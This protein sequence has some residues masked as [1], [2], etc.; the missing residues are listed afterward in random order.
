VNLP[1]G[2]AGRPRGQAA[3]ANGAA[4]G[5]ATGAADG[6]AVCEGGVMAQLVS[7]AYA[8]AGDL[9]RMERAL[10]ATYRSS[11]LRV[12]D[13]SWLSREHSHRE[14]SLYIRLWE[15]AEHGDHLA[16]GASG[17]IAW[18]Y[19]RPNGEFNVFAAPGQGTPDLFKELLDTIEA[20]SR[21]AIAAGDPPVDL[22]TY[23][24]D[25]SRSAEDRALAAALERRGFEVERDSS[26]VLKRSLDDAPTPVLPRGYRLA[27]VE[28]REQVAG[29]VEAHRAAFAPSELTVRKY[30]RVRRT[31]AYRPELDR[32]VLT[33]A[34]EVVAF[35]TA[36]LD[37]QNAS[38]LLEPVGTHPAHRRRGLA[39]AVCL[40]ALAALRRAGARTAQVGYSQ[41]AAYATYTGIGFAPLGADLAYSRAAAL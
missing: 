6:A 21:A 25:P 38:G 11:S 19:F 26:G 13:L 33:D 7:R 23:G 4:N 1:A 30:E 18:S 14:L 39:S 16:D 28:T 32:V 31:W 2:L 9:E 12:G 37:E 27:W 20:D 41:P 10:A 40:D 3:A 15:N 8:G 34:G 17:L 24:I 36:W 29:R 35:C 5:A 22:T